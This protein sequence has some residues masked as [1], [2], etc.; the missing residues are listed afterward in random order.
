MY[1]KSALLQKTEDKQVKWL[2]ECRNAFSTDS[3]WMGL[4]FQWMGSKATVHAQVKQ[5][6]SKKATVAIIQSKKEKSLK[7]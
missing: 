6:K 7:D 5:V 4:R 2:I 3:L 1:N